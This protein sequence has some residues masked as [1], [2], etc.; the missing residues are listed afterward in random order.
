AGSAFAGFAGFG[1]AP[2][3]TGTAQGDTE[4]AGNEDEDEEPKKNVFTGFSFGSSFGN[5]TSTTTSAFP[6]SGTGFGF[7]SAQTQKEGSAFGSKPKDVAS[8]SQSSTFGTTTTG[9]TFGSTTKEST[10]PVVES[11][12]APTSTDSKPTFAPFVPPALDVAKST[13]TASS[14]FQ[15][16]PSM[17]VQPF[18]PPKEL[19]TP[20][21]QPTAAATSESSEKKSDHQQYQLHRLGLNTSFKKALLAYLDEDPYVNLS[22]SFDVYRQHWE[23]L[24]KQYGSKTGK[25]DSTT[26][27]APTSVPESTPAFAP[28]T[29]QAV[30]K[31]KK[32]ATSTTFGA[33][34]SS[35]SPVKEGSTQPN[36]FSFASSTTTTT[37][38]SKPNVGF[39][40]GGTSVGSSPSAFGTQSTGGSQPASSGFFGPTQF[41]SAKPTIGFGTSFTANPSSSISTSEPTVAQKEDSQ[42][43]STTEPV[44]DQTKAADEEANEEET[45]E[46]NSSTGEECRVGEEDEDT[47]YRTLSKVF[48]FNKDRKEF[49]DLGVGHFRVNKHRDTHSV[50]LL[51]RQKHTNKITLNVA[52]FASMKFNYP[53]GKRDISFIAV[54]PD[55]VPVKYVLRVKT[56]AI[57]QE[58][59]TAL[60]EARDKVA[61]QAND[62]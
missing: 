19:A 52:M 6:T 27:A 32:T 24:E 20:S 48:T 61:N 15:N 57:A 29:N 39:S 22:F 41:G 54:G 7:S 10:P 17:K 16:P 18:Q 47:L 14:M 2:S 40:F 45:E 5:S 43:Q 9:F 62:S 4:E 28:N 56:P 38:T 58:L 51:C 33:F 25:T 49:V 46:G 44:A 23:S 3:S 34:G 37:E 12:P 35:A 36:P 21:S 60:E 50:R 31:E 53:P 42:T 26:T 59:L 55:Q 1:T 30:A 13:S 11:K 8:S